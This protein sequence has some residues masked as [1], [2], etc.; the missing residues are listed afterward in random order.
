[1][2]ARLDKKAQA[3]LIDLLIGIT[4]FLLVIAAGLTILDNQINAVREQQE[5]LAQ[6]KAAETALNQLVTSTGLTA[7]GETSWEDSTSIDE[8][9]FV[10]LALTDRIIFSE[11]INKF[12]E[13]AIN[14]YEKTKSKLLIG[15][16]FYFRLMVPGTGDNG[17][18]MTGC[19]DTM[20]NCEAGKT[21][22]DL[23][24]EG[25]KI[26]TVMKARRI[27][28]F[29]GGSAIAEITIFKTR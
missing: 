11:K 21:E 1:M 22:A 6:Q 5:L 23:V 2:S 13:Y 27:V 24:S 10:G 26:D 3:V 25:K 18:T 9:K 12:K 14:E 29:K 19:P 20:G 8:V 28:A 16:D 17:T 7:S 4:L 15:Q